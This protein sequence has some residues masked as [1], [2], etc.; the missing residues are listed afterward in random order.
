MGGK[1]CRSV[2]GFLETN[3]KVIRKTDLIILLKKT[4]LINTDD[5]SLL[6][7]AAVA[8]EGQKLQIQSN[9]NHMLYN[10]KHDILFD[11]Y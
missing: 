9:H 1:P 4:V 2:S 6:P 10:Y 7:P 5:T 11:N 8:A 3:H